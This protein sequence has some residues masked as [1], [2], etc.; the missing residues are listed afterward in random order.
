MCSDSLFAAGFSTFWHAELEA[1]KKRIAETHEN[2]DNNEDAVL[3]LPSEQVD[4]NHVAAQQSDASEEQVNPHVV[5]EQ[6]QARDRVD[7]SNVAAQQLGSS[8]EQDNPRVVAEQTQNRE[9]TQEPEIRAKSQLPSALVD[10]ITMSTHD[11]L[12]LA[13]EFLGSGYTEPVPRSG[14]YISA[15]G[16]RVFRMGESDILGWHKDRP[17][18]NFEI[19]APNP[20]KPGKMMITQNIHLFLGDSQ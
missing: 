6:T 8:E 9:Q 2:G 7:E 19:L 17:H 20:Q 5:A 18:V 4:E 15:D 1:Q 11:A 3:P 14:R 10:G 13:E 12:T 16:T